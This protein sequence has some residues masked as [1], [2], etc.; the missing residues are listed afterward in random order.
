MNILHIDTAT[1]V[2]SVALTI[3]GVL[4]AYRDHDEP[5]IHASKLTV[6]I[7]ELLLE[8]KIAIN[9]LS[10]ISV[11]KGPGSYTGL[12]IGVSVAKGICYALDVPLIAVNTLDAMMQGFKASLSE[13]SDRGNEL[14]TLFCPMIDARRMEVYTAIYDAH[15]S[16]IEPTAA[17]II[18]ADS[19]DYLA[20]KHQL[21]M[22]GEG[23][24][25]LSDLFS[26]HGSIQIYK[27]FQNSARYLI[28]ETLT[29]FN[30]Q[31]FEDIAY[32]EPFYLKDFVPT[33]PKRAIKS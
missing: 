9:Q 25:K 16:I 8:A 26:E 20:N 19:F 1:P 7:E 2:C 23:A 33:T 10:A 15:L 21:I 17:R 32:F 5:N 24:N 30:K 6:F 18:E 13:Q 11:S 27:G 22:F 12:R 28:P 31:E 29:R 4:S 14:N 3:N